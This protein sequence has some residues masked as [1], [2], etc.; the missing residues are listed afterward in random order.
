MIDLDE[1]PLLLQS[2]EYGDIE[3]Y[4]RDGRQDLQVIDQVIR[5]SARK[6][7]FMSKVDD[8]LYT[9]LQSPDWQS[10]LDVGAHIGSFSVRMVTQF[11]V[12]VIAYEPEHENYTILKANANKA[13]AKN[14][15]R[16]IRCVNKAVV[17]GDETSVRFYLNSRK[18][19]GM[20]SILPR[21]GRASI[22]VLA[23]K[24]DDV[25]LRNDITCVKM[26]IEG[27]EYEIIKHCSVLPVIEV[28]FLE[29][30]FMYLHDLSLYREIISILKKNFSSV[31]YL[32][33]PK[34]HWQ[35][36]I[37]AYKF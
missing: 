4:F 17:S 24:F 30:H 36:R 6:G 18:D 33:E 13:N 26:D 1:L 12:Q 35:T 20:H 14:G 15:N 28:L 31:T 16:F 2:T 23:E 5:P 21:R 3:L 22:T 37:V 11:G 19:A 9:S 27:A 34:K 7:D 25:V 32:Q 8:R 10:W 29:Y